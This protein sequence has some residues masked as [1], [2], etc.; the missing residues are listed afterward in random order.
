M[1][2]TVFTTARSP[3]GGTSPRRDGAVLGSD[4]GAPRHPFA[5]R[6]PGI[7]SYSCLDDGIRPSGALQEVEFAAAGRLTVEPAVFE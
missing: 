7:N 1:S 6:L 4:R 5:G 3:E 2:R